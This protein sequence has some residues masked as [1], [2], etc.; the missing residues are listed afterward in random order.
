MT[1]T[2]R[3]GLVFALPALMIA[4]ACG[5]ETARVI[6]LPNANPPRGQALIRQVGCAACHIIPGVDWPQGAVGP[7]LEGFADRNLI[8]GRFPNE[9]EALARW[10][11]D[12]PSMIPETGM[13]PM[14]LTEEE[15]RDVTAYLYTL[16]GR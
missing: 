13:T 5:G 15:A 7:S 16:H 11:R 4:S 2:A 9:P 8:A 14:P 12:A 10:V 6:D 3:R 1:F